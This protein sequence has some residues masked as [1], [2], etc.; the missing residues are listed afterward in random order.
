MVL[1]QFILQTIYVVLVTT[2]LC[3]SVF[4]FFFPEQFLA[5]YAILPFLFGFM[6]VLIFRSLIRSEEFALL[7]FTNRYF[8]LTTIKLLGTLVLII[9]FLVFN[10]NRVIP[11]LSSVLAVYLIFLAQEIIAILKFFKKKE[12]IENTHN[13]T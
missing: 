4:L 1:K 13:K 8:L 5:F 6:N 10:R 9:V 12:K 11:F 7:K 3:V 2:A